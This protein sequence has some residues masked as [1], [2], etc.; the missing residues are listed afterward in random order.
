ML[1]DLD[2]NE[3]I[4]KIENLQKQL[5]E[6]ESEN[7]LLQTDNKTYKHELQQLEQA[8]QAEAVTRQELEN[9]NMTLQSDNTG[10]KNELEVCK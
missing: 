3:A 5:E 9:Q 8:M 10:F 4:D 7:Q 1:L 6:I 2:L